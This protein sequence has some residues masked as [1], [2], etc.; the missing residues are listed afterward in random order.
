MILH[1]YF[2]SNCYFS[3]VYLQR[4]ERH[5]FQAG[6]PCGLSLI[7]SCFLIFPVIHVSNSSPTE[8]PADFPHIHEGAAD[9]RKEP[10]AFPDVEGVVG[11]DG[12]VGIICTI[13]NYDSKNDTWKTDFF[14]TVSS[15]QL[16][17]N[18]SNKFRGSLSKQ[19]LVIKMPSLTHEFCLRMSATRAFGSSSRSSLLQIPWD[20]WTGLCSQRIFEKNRWAFSFRGCPHISICEFR[21]GNLLRHS[22]TC[23]QPTQI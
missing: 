13:R 23:F 17:P 15:C 16:M 7:V 22:L 14:S 8:S 5:L 1:L 4:S 6:R 11:E 9:L 19:L 2:T 10:P 18:H 21:F 12:R 3:D 20:G